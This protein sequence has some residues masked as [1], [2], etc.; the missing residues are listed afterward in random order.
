LERHLDIPNHELAFVLDGASAPLRRALRRAERTGDAPEGLD[1]V[2]DG[3]ERGLCAAR[4]TRHLV[5]LR[6]RR[7]AYWD[8][9]F[10]E[11]RHAGS[12][13]L[14][15]A[16]EKVYSQ[17]GED[18]LLRAVFE[19]IGTTNRFFAE[20]GVESGDECNTR[21]LLEKEGWR[22]LWMDADPLFVKR[23]REVFAD[24]PVR[25][26]ESFV[27]V[28]NV[29][30][31][32]AAGEVPDEPDLLGIDVDGN[33]YWLWRRIAER[34]RPRV[35]IVEFNGRFVPE[36]EWVQPYESTY[37]WD[38]TCRA[39]ASL[40]ALHRLGREIGY[41]LVCCDSQGVNALFVRADLLPA[42]LRGQ[43]LPT[44]LYHPPRCSRFFF[45]HPIDPSFGGG[46]T[47][48]LPL[49][50]IKR[51]IAVRRLRP[52]WRRST[53]QRRRSQEFFV[54]VALSNHTDHV[55]S[56]AHPNPILLSY[57]WSSQASPD[58]FDFG[59]RTPL[60]APIPPGETATQ[61]I[62]VRCPDV[63]GRYQLALTFVQEQVTWGVSL[64]IEHRI[65]A[66]VQ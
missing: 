20:F 15:E 1:P 63:K 47:E 53:I 40:D 3:A 22:G 42:L 66:E 57:Y 23:A 8:R 59:I 5:E 34:Y 11:G 25:I 61:E 17:N 4:R 44:L 39:G 36:R 29:L 54:P 14:A 30:D 52:W 7:I 28:E 51:G 48:P 35:A 50:T 16:E 65:P 58:D 18:G 56:A 32:F 24:R 12:I 38:R 46:A 2:L 9:R 33:D 49:E 41:E 27:T 64:G 19:R 31:L 60:T 37:A 26:L 10:Q 55:L 43:T 45:G 6:D 21:L 13:D 62:L